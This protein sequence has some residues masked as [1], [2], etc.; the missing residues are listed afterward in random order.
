MVTFFFAFAT[1]TFF[2]SLAAHVAES[3]STARI[4]KD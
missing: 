1:I 2:G 3:V 4:P